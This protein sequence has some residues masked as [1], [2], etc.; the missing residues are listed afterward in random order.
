MSRYYLDK[1][2]YRVDRNASL[3]REYMRDPATFVPHWEQG[4][5]RQLTEVERSSGLQFTVEERRALVE[6]DIPALYALGAHPFL[7]LTV[8]IPVYENQFPDFITF[9]HEFRNKIADLG[10]PDFGT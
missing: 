2:L 9:A 6:R 1:F 5:G 8:M 7:L 3:L 4:E 10:H